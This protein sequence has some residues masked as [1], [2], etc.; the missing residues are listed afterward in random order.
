VK[1]RSGPTSLRRTKF[2]LK[3]ARGFSAS[4]ASTA[5]VAATGRFQRPSGRSY[6][7]GISWSITNDSDSN[8]QGSR[9]TSS[10]SGC[11]S[12]R[13]AD[14][15][16]RHMFAVAPGCKLGMQRGSKC[17]ATKRSTDGPAKTGGL[18]EETPVVGKNQGRAAT[19]NYGSAADGPREFLAPS[20]NQHRARRHLRS[21]VSGIISEN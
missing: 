14:R 6:A 3:L 18:S 16:D 20:E 19:E 12:V 4:K 9:K 1:S 2:N 10:V 5:S 17:S 15:R 21:K 11:Q 7:N 8:R 13:G